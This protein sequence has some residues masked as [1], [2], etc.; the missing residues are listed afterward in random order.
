MSETDRAEA[1]RYLTP[2]EF[3]LFQRMPA[4]DQRHGIAVLR[5]IREAGYE[6]PELFI[7]ALLHDVGKTRTHLRLWE[8]AL[9]VLGR[10]FMPGVAACLAQGQP[11]GLARP[12]VTAARH[13]DWGADMVATAGGSVLAVALIRRHAEPLA[14]LE[15][16]EDHLLAALQQAD[17][18]N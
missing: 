2:A 8:R 10:A 13:P 12:F 18:E 6:S 15:S 16:Q 17:N 9:V 3:E 1:Q 7:A 5:M 4:N 11:Y 14:K